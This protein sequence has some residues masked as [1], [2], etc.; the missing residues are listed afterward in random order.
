MTKYPQYLA[1]DTGISAKD[2]KIYKAN[3]SL[4]DGNGNINVDNDYIA[5]GWYTSDSE[6]MM[7]ISIDGDEVWQ[8][9]LVHIV[10]GSIT[11]RLN[12]TSTVS[13]S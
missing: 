4:T 5:D 2:R 12:I 6:P 11:E 1:G 7:V 10:S 9:E 3:H 8:I 13:G